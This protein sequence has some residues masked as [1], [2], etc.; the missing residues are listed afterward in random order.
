LALA[1]IIAQDGN[2]LLAAVYAPA[3]PPWMRTVPAVDTL[4]RVWVQQFYRDGDTLR[5]RTDQD[6]T[7]PS[8]IMIG[9]PYDVDAHYSKKG[10]TS[11][12]GYKVHLTET[13][14]DEGPNL[15][16]HVETT[17]API[18]DGATTTVHGDVELTHL[19]QDSMTLLFQVVR[20]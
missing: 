17:A 2:T 13:C 12:V 3:A 9:S 14:D 20:S 1:E 18:A 6:G 5:W 7:P 11:W 19:R 15:I 10:E 4:R 16:T 8:A